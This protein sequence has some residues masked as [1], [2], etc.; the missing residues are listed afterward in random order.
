[1][2]EPVVIDNKYVGIIVGIILVVGIFA[3]LV[4]AVILPSYQTIAAMSWEQ[5]E[6]TI[7]KVRSKS[8]STNHKKGSTNFK[9][10]LTYSY[11]FDGKP[12]QGDRYDFGVGGDGDQRYVRRVVD[13]LKRN[14]KTVCYVNPNEPSESVLMRQFPWTALAIGVAFVTLV[15]GGIVAWIKGVRPDRLL[16]AAQKAQRRI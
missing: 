14:K 12:Y 6:C 16:D 15:L 7:T 10:E 13:D 2:N 4:Y 11:E 1:M 3:A 8:L 9:V 5:T